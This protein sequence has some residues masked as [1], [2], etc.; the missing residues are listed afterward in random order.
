[1]MMET[2]LMMM[3]TANREMFKVIKKLNRENFEMFV[4]YVGGLHFAMA[5]VALFV[6]FRR[7][8]NLSIFH[9]FLKFLNAIGFGKLF[10]QKSS[11]SSLSGSN[12]HTLGS[13]SS[14]SFKI[15]SEGNGISGPSTLI[16]DISSP[17]D[18]GSS[19]SSTG[20]K[21]SASSSSS[22]SWLLSQT[23][24]PTHTISLTEILASF[25]AASWVQFVVLAT[26]HYRSRVRNRMFWVVT[27]PC[28][29]LSLLNSASLY[30]MYD[31]QKRSQKQQLLTAQQN[32]IQPF[33]V[34]RPKIISD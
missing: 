16:K 15:G 27:I 23:Y 10:S 7:L 24:Y 3:T 32:R 28:L 12:V 13:S 4:R 31:Q 8:R 2:L 29:F 5:L 34:K 20:S 30:I 11:S 26:A 22:S 17:L 14:S 21:L 33:R 19:S 6:L 25:S 1:M 18:G 9:K